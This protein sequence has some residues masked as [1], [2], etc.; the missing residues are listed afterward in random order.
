MTRATRSSVV[1]N[2]GTNTSE[3]IPAKKQSMK[4]SKKDPNQPKVILTSDNMWFI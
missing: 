4:R 1:G 3:K 2:T